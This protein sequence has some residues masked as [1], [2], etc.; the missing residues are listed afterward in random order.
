MLPHLSDI[1]SNKEFTAKDVICLTETWLTPN[2]T[3]PKTLFPEHHFYQCLRSDAYG[4][5]HHILSKLSTME[6]GGVAMFVKKGLQP[7]HFRFQTSNVE[8]VAVTVNDVCFVTMYRPPIYH[9]DLFINHLT[10]LLREIKSTF[11]KSVILGDF[12][13]S[14]L[15]NKQNN[16]VLA[17]KEFGYRQLVDFATTEAGSCLDLVFIHGLHQTSIH[18]YPTYYSFHD[19][20]E[21]SIHTMD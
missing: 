14:I 8:A 21:L 11:E 17:F 20:V 13:T 1:R 4:T 7:R 10:D 5:D 9:L 18:L 12:N 6:R 16:L 19:S 2:T 3:A 15:Q